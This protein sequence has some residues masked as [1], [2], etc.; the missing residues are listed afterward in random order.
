MEDFRPRDPRLTEKLNELKRMIER[1]SKIN[2]GPGLTMR[3]GAGGVNFGLKR[4][5]AESRV[6]KVNYDGGTVLVLD[7]TNPTVTWNRTNDDRPVR[8]DGPTLEY[9]TTTH[10]LVLYSRPVE[11]DRGG[12]LRSIGAEVST[13]ITEAVACTAT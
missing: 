11:Y 2:V 3:T 12:M 9:N 7:H 1:L 13:E 4:T 10:K 8:Y 6:R 5:P